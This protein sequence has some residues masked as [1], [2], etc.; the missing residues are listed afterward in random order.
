MEWKS[1]I[2]A[3]IGVRIVVAVLAAV[4]S[5]GVF[6][7]KMSEPEFYGGTMQALEEKQTAVLEMT[8]GIAVASTAI[9][10]LPGDTTTPI[11]NQLMN[12]SQWLLLA[13]CT[14]FLEKYLLTVLGFAVFKVMIPVGCLLYLMGLFLDSDTC[15]ILCSK[16][17]TLGLVF[18]FTIPAGVKASEIIENTY[19]MSLEVSVDETAELV[20]SMEETEGT[21][22]KEGKLR[23]FLSKVKDSAVEAPQKA[24]ELLNAFI[25]QVAVMVVTTCLIPI[26]ILLFMIWVGKTIVG[27][28]V[29]LPKRKKARVGGHSSNEE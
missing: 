27:A 5:F 18:L 20:Q 19:Q 10:A 1:K 6:A 28:E 2:N 11:A 3:K 21:E 13:L 16:L 17:I 12:L 7:E 15:R 8:A 22:E 24:K 4:L 26:A 23:Q 29:S 9:S 25:E 14:I